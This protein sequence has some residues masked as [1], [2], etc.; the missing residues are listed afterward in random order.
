M[1]ASRSWKRIC[2]ARAFS[3]DMWFTP[4]NWLSPNS[5]RS[6]ARVGADV[7]AVGIVVVISVS[8][9]QRAQR[10]SD[11]VAGS[12]CRRL[13]R[14]GAIRLQ[15]RFL[16]GRVLADHRDHAIRD[17]RGGEVVLAR[18]L[19]GDDALHEGVQLGAVLLAAKVEPRRFG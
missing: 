10:R 13:C 2:C 15:S 3:S 18:G 17:G 11:P 9:P 19:A 14:R 8:Y 16:A 5:R 12:R 6:M 7:C 4:K 1:I